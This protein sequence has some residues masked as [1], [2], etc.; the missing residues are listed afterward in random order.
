MSESGGEGASAA[1]AAASRPREWWWKCWI[2]PLLLTLLLLPTSLAQLR[3]RLPAVVTADLRLNQPRYATLPN[4]MKAKKKRCD[5]LTPEVGGRRAEQVV[6]Q[7]H[8]GR[9]QGV[10]VGGRTSTA[11]HGPRQHVPSTAKL[12]LPAPAR[13]LLCCRTW[14]WTWR[15][16]CR[17]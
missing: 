6:C 8:S 3:L 11:S 10:A 5:C 9:G 1:A 12:L 2:G 13:Y 4:I 7:D 15:R 17:C 16:A 14:A